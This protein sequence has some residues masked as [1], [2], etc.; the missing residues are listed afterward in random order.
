[1]R[2]FKTMTISKRSILKPLLEGTNKGVVICRGKFVF[3]TT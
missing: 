2:S 1:M 3:F